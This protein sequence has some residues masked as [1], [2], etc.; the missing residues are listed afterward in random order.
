MIRLLIIALLA[1]V[2]ARA[3][4]ED[5]A[6][7][8]DRLRAHL[9]AADVGVSR[10]QVAW[11][12]AFGAAAVG[13]ATLALTKW[14]PFGDFDDKFRDTMIVS[15]AK[16]TIGLGSRI[17]MPLRVDLP[18]P[19]TDRCADL[20]ALRA[21][22]AK[23]GRKERDTFW[24]THLGGTALN[25]AGGG[26]LWY[27][28]SLGTGAVSFAMSYPVGVTSAYTL[29]RGTWHVWRG[30]RASWNVT[31]VPTHESTLFVL[32]GIF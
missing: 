29:P 2:P 18:T 16:A 17:L 8:A 22:V 28:H 13:T 11:S 32:G 15:S 14:N 6:A 4:A 21:S 20:V 24:L 12:I 23:L 5:C 31:V 7:S 30:E 9:E 10:W 26:L 27:L 25:L 3:H 19:N 1:T